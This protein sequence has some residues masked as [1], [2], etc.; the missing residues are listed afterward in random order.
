MSELWWL[1][2]LLVF[3]GA[4]AAA[5]V[6]VRFVR[7]R[8]SSPAVRAARSARAQAQARRS[9]APL[10][11]SLDSLSQRASIALVQ[12]DNRVA[13]S[14]NELEFARAQFGDSRTREFALTLASADKQR[15]EAFALAQL[16]DDAFADTER[17][18]REWN[19]RILA[20]ASQITAAL[21]EYETEFGSQRRQEANA[22]QSLAFLRQ[23]LNKASERITQAA[24][25]NR[26]LAARFAPTTIADLADAIAE[27]QSAQAS[28]AEL[29]D[30][31]ETLTASPTPQPVVP[32]LTRAQD[33]LLLADEKLARVEGRATDLDAATAAVDVLAN[34]LATRVRSAKATTAAPADPES[35]ATLIAAIAET[36]RVLA[37][38]TR[39]SHP[40]ST[41]VPSV[42]QDP[43]A[44][45]E[46]LRQAD[47]QLST[48]IATER[49]QADRLSHARAALTGADAIA[50]STI[51]R[52]SEAVASHRSSVG[53]EARTRLADA[54]RLLELSRAE[55]D[56]VKALDV[57]RAA[58]A[59]AEDADALARYRG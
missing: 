34:E 41:S 26:E 20:I 47:D 49:N 21:D 43:F 37:T 19:G 23:R 11:E 29:A 55:S 36:E 48:A 25:T 54:Q 30:Q 44:Q 42:L 12:L 32:L 4:G 33:A 27:A 14:Q 46:H 8:R 24:M 31:V 3:G 52:A 56:P 58:N 40:S 57:A 53:A 9:G 7:A 50:V 1:P 45:L 6:G 28:A 39:G 35:G 59:R 5:I 17:E 13:D 2:S 18:T 51:R 15:A 10:R 38:T 22:S 16:R